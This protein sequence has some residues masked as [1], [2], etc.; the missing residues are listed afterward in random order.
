MAEFIISATQPDISWLCFLLYRSSFQ[1]VQDGLVMGGPRHHRSRVKKSERIGTSMV[2]MYK[3]V[4]RRIQQHI[5]LATRAS[6]QLENA[7][8]ASRVKMSDP[9]RVKMYKRFGSRTEHELDCY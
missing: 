8:W 6:A 1:E 3:I 4:G 7:T 5:K 2:K 9:S